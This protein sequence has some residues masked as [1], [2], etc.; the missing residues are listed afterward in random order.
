DRIHDSIVKPGE[1]DMSLGDDQVLIVARIGDRGLPTRLLRRA[2]AGAGEVVA[3]EILA[4]HR[5]AR[6]KVAARGSTELQMEAVLVELRRE[7]RSAPV[8]RIE[9]ERR[10]PALREIFNRDRRSERNVLRRIEAQIVCN[11]LT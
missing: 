4:R 3:V 6:G 7:I 10:R 8:E 1:R 2:A 5:I 9:V 11:E